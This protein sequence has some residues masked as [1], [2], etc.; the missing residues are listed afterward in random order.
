[1]ANTSCAVRNRWNKKTYFRIN[2]SVPKGKRAI[3]KEYAES[4]GMSM[5]GLIN[6]LLRDEIGMTAQEWGFASEKL[7]EAD[8]SDEACEEERGERV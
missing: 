2:L 8:L 7:C 5:S 1:M 4:R 6:A 3:I